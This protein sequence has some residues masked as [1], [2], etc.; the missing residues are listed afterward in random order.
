MIRALV[1]S[2]SSPPSLVIPATALAQAPGQPPPL[3]MAVDLKKVPVGAW[4]E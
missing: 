1:L 3:P 4:A 2:R